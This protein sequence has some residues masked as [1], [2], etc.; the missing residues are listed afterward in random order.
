VIRVDRHDRWALVTLDRPERRNALSVA[1]R[2]AVSDALDELADDA[3]VRAVAIIGA[4]GTFSAGFDLREFEQALEDPGF[5]DV[6]WASSDRFHH[7]LLTFPLPLVA[8]VDGP[9]LA[10]GFDLAVCCDLRL[11]SA[12]AR[13]AHPE[14]SFG[15][16]VYRPLRELVG[17][18]IARDLVLTGRVVDAA[19]ALALH[20]VTDVVPPEALP[21]ALDAL[22]HQIVAAPRDIVL[23]TK[24]K[25]IDRAGIELGPTLSL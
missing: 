12:T 24:A 11:A 10:G 18:A 3:T 4:A 22:M 17:G 14:V 19:E 23:R 13:F 1:L 15:D 20:L 16:I 21:A 9:A 25:L 5:A 8:A 7:R 6:L 2:D